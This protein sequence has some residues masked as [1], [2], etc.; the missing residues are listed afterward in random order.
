[1]CVELYRGSDYQGAGELTNYVLTC[2]NG[3][4][5]YSSFDSVRVSGSGFEGTDCH[6][7]PDPNCQ[8]EILDTGN[9]LGG[10]CVDMPGARSMI[11]YF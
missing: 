4:F 11:W 2:N 3:C 7:F 5:Q 8:N 10:K 9:Q 1:E 6:I